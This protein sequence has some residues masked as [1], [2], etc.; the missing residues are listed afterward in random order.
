MMDAVSVL[1]SET[2]YENFEAS[3]AQTG[4]FAVTSTVVSFPAMMQLT[5]SPPL[6]QTPAHLPA[7]LLTIVQF[8]SVPPSV[9]HRSLNLHWDHSKLKFV[10]IPR[11]R[12]AT[13]DG[14]H[15]TRLWQRAF[16]VSHIVC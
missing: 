3:P 10:N 14:G 6:A 11:N 9:P 2:Q 1:V 13:W 4:I 8:S 7:A 15:L 5:T 16:I 12:S